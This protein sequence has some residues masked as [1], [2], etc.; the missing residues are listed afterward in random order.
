MLDSFDPD[1]ARRLA[2]PGL[3]P[4]CISKV[5]RIDFVCST[6][7]YRNVLKFETRQASM[8]SRA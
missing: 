5:Y 7:T 1:Q 8:L 4:N 3:D 6:K 2:G